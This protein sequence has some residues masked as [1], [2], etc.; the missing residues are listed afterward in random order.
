MLS[1]INSY[2]VCFLSVVQRDNMQGLSC[3]ACSKIICKEFVILANVIFGS[4]DSDDE[5]WPQIEQFS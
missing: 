2:V 1:V 4:G 3:K 5:R